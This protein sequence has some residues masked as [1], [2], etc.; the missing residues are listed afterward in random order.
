MTDEQPR[1]VDC[2]RETTLRHPRL[3]P[4]CPSCLENRTIALR[5]R[6]CGASGPVLLGP[7]CRCESPLERVFSDEGE[8]DVCPCGPC[9]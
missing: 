6:K 4:M 3:G 5:C 7:R 2:D 1:C 9:A 8:A